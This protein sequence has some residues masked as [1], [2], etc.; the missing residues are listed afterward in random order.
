MRGTF[1]ECEHFD[2]ARQGRASEP[3]IPANCPQI[4]LEKSVRNRHA[5]LYTAANRLRNSTVFLPEK[6]S[7]KHVF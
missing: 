4:C 6:T 7:R 5:F 3:W 1:P 2:N